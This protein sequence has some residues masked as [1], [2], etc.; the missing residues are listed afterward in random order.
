MKLT[1]SLLCALLVS[2]TMLLSVLPTAEAASGREIKA[3]VQDTLAEF[4]HDISGADDVL[5][6]AKGV[7]VFPRI[8]QGGI[9]IGG[10]YGEGEL[11]TGGKHADFY[12][13]IAASYGFQLGGQRKSVILA[14][15]NDEALEHFRTSSG[16]KVGA[17]ASA[18]IF[19]VGAEGGID[20]ATLNKPILAFVIDQKGLMYNLSL[21]GSKISKIKK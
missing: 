14:F 1:V 2:L 4:K 19:V 13:I 7:L 15:M 12:R 9:G 6:K 16:W 8:Y 21:E 3:R 17:D 10:Q 5:A 20:T 18:A 11:L